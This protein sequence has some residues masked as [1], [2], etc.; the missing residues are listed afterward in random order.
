MVIAAII[1]VASGVGMIIVQANSIGAGIGDAIQTKFGNVWIIRMVQSAI[2]LAIALGMYNRMRKIKTTA[3]SKAQTSL[4]PRGE[5]VALLVVGIAVLATTTMIS[6]AAS[7][8]QSTS[9]A[10]DFIHNVIASIW[11]GGVIYLAFVV[12]PELRR[13]AKESSGVERQAIASA[14]TIGIP[15][16]SIVVLALLGAIMIT[17]P[18]LLYSLEP[19]LDLTL[20][21]LYGKALIAKLILAGG[22]AAI[23]GYNQR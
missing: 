7:T 11:I 3:D 17:G 14:L 4:L 18:L 6:H 2:V 22:M 12:I 15:R 20:S 13:R 23:G 10:L 9:I 1:L 21:S 5:L 8:S 19:N 16:F